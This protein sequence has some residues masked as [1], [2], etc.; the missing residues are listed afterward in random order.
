MPQFPDLKIIDEL[1]PNSNDINKIFH[2]LLNQ[3]EYYLNLK[4]NLKNIHISIIEEKSKQ[5]DIF[6]YGTV[7]IKEN[8][9][10]YIKLNLDCI[11]FFPFILLREIFK[12][13]IKKELVND[14]LINLTIN[15]IV[16]TTLSKNSFLNE[17]KSIIRGKVESITR[18]DA[19]FSYIT[20][21]DR[22]SKF[23]SNYMLNF[24]PNP[25]QFFFNYLDK[26]PDLT[27]GNFNTFN[28]ILFKN[29]QLSLM[30]MM[31]NNYFVE[32]LRSIIEIFY[33]V[34][35]YSNLLEYKK[36]FQLLKKQR[37]LKTELSLRKFNENMNII[38]KSYISPSYQINWSV[39]DIGVILLKM[40]FNPLLTQSKIIKILKDIPFLIT[41]KKSFDC[42]SY[43]II[44][45]LVLPTK[46]LSD[47]LKLMEGLKHNRYLIDFNFLMRINQSHFL[48]LN[49]FKE[50]FSDKIIPNPVYRNYNINNVIKSQVEFGENFLKNPLS[51]LD[52]LILDRIRWYSFS[53]LGFERNEENISILRSDLFNE[54][55]S[56]QSFIT[57]LKQNL[58][59]LYKNDDLRNNIITFVKDHIDLGFYYF[60]IKIESYLD[61]IK[62][63]ENNILNEKIQDFR[64]FK[65]FL[66]RKFPS[67]SIEQNLN[68][69]KKEFQFFIKH[70]YRFFFKSKQTYMIKVSVYKSTKELLNFCSSLKI[71]DLN[72]LV[73]ILVDKNLVFRLFQAKD[74]ILRDI[75]EEYH[76]KEINSQVLTNILDK[77]IES[78]PP[79][80]FPLMIN[81]VATKIFVSDHFQIL[82][83]DFSKLDDKISILSH[84]FPRTLITKVK[85]ITSKEFFYYLEL[86]MPALT[87]KEKKLFVSIIYNLFKQNLIYGKNHIWSGFI[88]GFSIR[89]FYDYEKKNFFYTSDLYNQYE[90]YINST[91]QDINQNFIIKKFENQ[92]IFWL[93]ND[94]LIKFVKSVNNRRAREN[95]LYEHKHLDMLRTFYLNIEEKLLNV[96]DFVESKKEF[97]FQNY[98]KSI[99]FIPAFQYFNLRK[100]TSYFYSSDLNKMNFKSLL[101]ANFLKVEYPACIDDSIPFLI[102]YVHSSSQSDNLLS[103]IIFTPDNKIRE[104]CGFITNKT[105]VLFHFELNFTPEGWDYDSIAFKEHLQN[106]LFNIEYNFDI[107]N[108]KTFLFSKNNEESTYRPNP[109]E[110]LD[111]CEIFEYSSIDIKSYIG[112]KKVK[113]VER[114]QSLLKKGLI[115]PY[116]TLK[117]LGFQESI[118]LIIPDLNQESVSIL[119]KIF[120]WFNYGFLHEIEGMYFIFGFDEPIEFTH[121]LMMEL[122]FPKCEL[123]EFKQ[124]FDMVF[125]Y[126]QIKHYLILKDFV[127]GDTLVKNIY[128]DTT[129]FE[130]HH[131]LRNIINDDK[132][133]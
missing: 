10:Y 12:C 38:K 97:F 71:F 109:T 37:I 1:P 99:K 59:E 42:F 50:E 19:G 54:I 45:Y 82:L 115:Y 61:L 7:K 35:K 101:D 118:Y 26:H 18:K 125:E 33:K 72:L 32:S 105:H 130:T 74:K 132:D 4:A 8:N 124:L 16:I 39:V 117:N 112:T 14:I 55:I 89:N 41:P 129:F 9:L 47:S 76:D 6:N 104:F 119:I 133:V 66:T 94:D 78:D 65:I 95:E 2:N 131:P 81:T 62:I 90:K 43:N 98:L 46:Y 120:G 86:S 92:K 56:Q 80:I 53:G 83:K 20:N 24:K 114:I 48:N 15:Q 67:T 60:K 30:R 34:K 91:F 122:Y 75:Y 29:Y 5:I 84:I 107:P 28:F 64:E 116:M 63:L 40:K 25:I 58:K 88:T 77:F 93:E 49:Y 100:F 103:D 96:E 73:K 121:G 127:N 57:N 85:D 69:S 27:I 36:H 111:L 31:I 87:K 22:L 17:W 123:S 13:F 110:F 52:F 79:F 113:T 51:I 126:L 3:F 44:A 108:L 128:E 102:D 70:L 68:Y 23:F 106:V 21:F 11:R